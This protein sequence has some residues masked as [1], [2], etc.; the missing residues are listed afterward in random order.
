[1]LFLDVYVNPILQNPVVLGLVVIVFGLM[2]AM[3]A[4]PALIHNAICIYVFVIALLGL[5]VFVAMDVNNINDLNDLME[6][7]WLFAGVISTIVLYIIVVIKKLT[8]KE[9]SKTPKG[10][11]LM[12]IVFPPFLGVWVAVGIYMN[13]IFGYALMAF[14]LMIGLLFIFGKHVDT[15]S[16]LDEVE[17]DNEDKKKEEK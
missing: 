5:A 11:L 12:Y 7:K 6:I 9:K 16:S 2:F 8:S 4:K 3:L 1:M 14:A 10:D 17:D 15:Y 13:S